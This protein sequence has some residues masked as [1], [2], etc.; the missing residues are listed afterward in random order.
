MPRRHTNADQPAGGDYRKLAQSL[1][2][3]WNR[4]HGRPTDTERARERERSARHAAQ[5]GDRVTVS[6]A[7]AKLAAYLA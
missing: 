3:E 5:R 2:D 7:R 4:A 1:H 6:D